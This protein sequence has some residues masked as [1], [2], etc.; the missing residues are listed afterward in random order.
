M[1]DSAI[2]HIKLLLGTDQDGY[3]VCVY[4][5]GEKG[6]RSEGYS[7]ATAAKALYSARKA[8]E[9]DFPGTEIVE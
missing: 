2:T 3:Y 6:P 1:T 8:A 7:G 5:N 9:R 4:A